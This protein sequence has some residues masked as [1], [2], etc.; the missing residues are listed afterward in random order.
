MNTNNI[1]CIGLTG[2]MYAGK[3]T[4]AYFFNKVI[5]QSVTDA[6]AK[7][8][9]EILMNYF[10]FTKEQLYDPKEKTKFNPEWGMT[11]REAMQKLGTECIRNNFHKDAWIKIME[12][13]IQKH[14]DMKELV[15]IPDVRF[16]NEANL[17]HKMGGIVIEII[18]WKECK[19]AREVTVDGALHQSLFDIMFAPKEIMREIS[20]RV[21]SC[22][23]KF[24]HASEKG[25]DDNLVDFR[26]FNDGTIED[27]YDEIVERVWKRPNT[28]EMPTVGGSL[29]NK[30]G[31][32]FDP[33][34][35]IEH[36]ENYRALNKVIFKHK[37]LFPGL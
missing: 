25:I 36:G 5:S 27:F 21:G 26:V 12:K 9:K 35:D 14:I 11:N 8:L 20:E 4:A 13:R 19:P 37:A 2:K 34:V 17:I 16:D 18:R 33:M 24:V 28:D 1:T 6:F 29:Y 10:G 7:P 3:D 31:L 15:I 32:Y 30:Y 22:F 23:P